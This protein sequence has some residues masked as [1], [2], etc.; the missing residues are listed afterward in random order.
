MSVKR[1]VKI[2]KYI[3]YNNKAL[4]K[5][6]PEFDNLFKI[7]PVLESVVSHCRSTTAEEKLPIDEQIISTKGRSSL[8]QYL[9]KNSNKWGIKVCASCCI[10]GIIY[11]LEVYTEK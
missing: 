4:P 11:D 7:R 5:T 1:F 3:H 6:H 10:S 2:K 8:K 9:L